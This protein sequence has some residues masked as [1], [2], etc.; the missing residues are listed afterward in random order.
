MP[1]TPINP[2]H[3][4]L[5]LASRSPR[6]RELLTQIGVQFDTL[7]F[8]SAPREDH[9]VDETPLAAETP[10]DY[11]QRVARAKAKFGVALVHERRLPM[12]LVLSAD[13]T[14]EFEGRIIGKPADADEARTILGQLSGRTHRVLT[15]VAVAR[16]ARIESVLSISEVSFGKIDPADIRRYVMSGEPLDKAGA[17]GIQ[18]LGRTL[19]RT[20]EGDYFN[21]VGLPV[22]KTMRALEAF[23]G[24]SD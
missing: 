9:Q 10:I 14:L 3:Y 6:R 5:Y 17:Y 7:F 1:N 15:A 24:K 16:E 2:H 18:G 8:R 21:V 4:R 22:A 20:I 13:T 11:V 19:V 12:Q 23:V